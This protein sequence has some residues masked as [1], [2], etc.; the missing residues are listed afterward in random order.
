MNH[1]HTLRKKCQSNPTPHILSKLKVYESDLH[2]LI[3][4]KTSFEAK[5]I[6]NY[7]QKNNSKF[8]SILEVLVVKV[9]FPQQSLLS[10]YC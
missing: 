7:S 8:P 1:L 2:K 6:Q 5:L 10:P 9:L 4:A 3:A